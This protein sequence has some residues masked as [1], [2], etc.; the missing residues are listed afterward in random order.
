MTPFVHN[1]PPWRDSVMALIRAGGSASPSMRRVCWR[2]EGS[3]VSIGGSLI[4]LLCAEG[5]LIA[6]AWDDAQAPTRVE[7]A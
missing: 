2:A 1:P 3:K 7:P 4:E 6:T 5:R